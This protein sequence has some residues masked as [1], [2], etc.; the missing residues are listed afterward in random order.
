M[1]NNKEENIEKIITKDVGNKLEEDLIFLYNDYKNKKDKYEKIKTAIYHLIKVFPAYSKYFPE[2][3]IQL[4]DNSHKKM[5]I[6][7]TVYKILYIEGDLKTSQIYNFLKEMGKYDKNKDSR[8][9]L[10]VLLHNANKNN[11]KGICRI[12]Y[13]RWG[14]RP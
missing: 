3:V 1:D 12:R 2:F 8:N 11:K 5:S 9:S 13:N 7:D 14:I 4:K 10:R 6:L